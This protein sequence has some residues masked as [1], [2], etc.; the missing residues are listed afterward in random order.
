MTQ[1][2]IERHHRSTKNMVNLQK[3][4]F[5]WELE[6]DITRFVE[7]CNNECYYE[8]LIN[9]TPADVYYGRH[10]KIIT[11]RDQIKRK[12]FKARRRHI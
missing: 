4:Y 2:K 1:G 8:A 10:R 6:R 11:R 3:Y 12:T 5:P 7:Y 9:A